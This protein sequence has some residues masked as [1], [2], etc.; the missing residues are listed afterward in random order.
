MSRRG[1][2]YL[3][4]TGRAVLAG[5]PVVIAAL[6][7]AAN[8]GTSA[9]IMKA[10]KPEER[11]PYISGMVEALAYARYTEG[12]DERG[13]NCIYDWFYRKTGTLDSIYA[14]FGQY[15]TYPPAAVVAALTRKVCAK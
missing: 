6:P 7:V 4:N 3:L 10:L 12:K 9:G 15:P 11:Y 14:A 8:D 2:H 5:L 1:Q 13:M